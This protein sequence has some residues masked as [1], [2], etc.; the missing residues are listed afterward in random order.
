MS[1]LDMRLTSTAVPGQPVPELRPSLA[2]ED[3]VEP[4]DDELEDLDELLADDD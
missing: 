2:P 4:E 3:D 1:S